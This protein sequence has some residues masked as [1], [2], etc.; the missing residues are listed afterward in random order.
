MKER[1]RRAKKVGKANIVATTITLLLGLLGWYLFGYWQISLT[2]F[3]II[4]VLL[5][6]GYWASIAWVKKY[7]SS[8]LPVDEVLDDTLEGVSL[9]C[10][11]LSEEAQ[12]IAEVLRASGALS[13]GVE[14]LVSISEAASEL[15][16]RIGSERVLRQNLVSQNECLSLSRELPES[17]S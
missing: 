3:S 2:V 11:Y 7:Y 6:V 17:T 15:V 5:L 8:P 12:H 10:L 4:N 9:D 13:D 16:V 14:L 1:E